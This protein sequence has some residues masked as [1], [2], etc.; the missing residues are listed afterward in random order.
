MGPLHFIVQTGKKKNPS[1]YYLYQQRD[2][3]QLYN[4]TRNISHHKINKATYSKKIQS[5]NQQRITKCLV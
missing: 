1:V 4:E 3:F 5:L 2:N